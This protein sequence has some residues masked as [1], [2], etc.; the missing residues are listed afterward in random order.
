VLV[1]ALVHAHHVGG[2]AAALGGGGDQHLEAGTAGEAK[3]G[4]AG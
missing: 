2:D 3:G 4:L 1:V